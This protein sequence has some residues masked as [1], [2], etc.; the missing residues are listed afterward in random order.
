MMAR[1]MKRSLSLLLALVMCLSLVNIS[2]FATGYEDQVMDGYFVVGSDGVTETTE[3]ATNSDQGYTV[4]KTINQTGENAF[5]ITLK[6]ETQQT[7]QTNDAAVILVI[8]VS[9]SMKSCAE[10]GGY[11]D[12]WGYYYHGSN[13]PG[14]RYGETV[15]YKDS[16]MAATISAAKNF[17]KSLKDN[18][19]EGGNLY[20][21]VVKFSTNAYKVCDWIDISEGNNI[22]TVNRAIDRLEADGGTNLDA[23]LTLAYNRLGMQTVSSASSKYTVLLTDGEPTYYYTGNSDD[24]NQIGSTGWNSTVGGSG[25]S[26]ST[27]TVNQAISAAN[28][29]K[30]RS[31][32]YTI[33][34]GVEDD[35]CLEGQTIHVCAHCEESRDKHI[36]E[37]LCA[38]CGRPKSDHPRGEWGIRWCPTGGWS[39]WDRKTYYFC[40]E[41]KETQYE[42]KTVTNGDLTVGSFLS[43]SIATSPD[44]AYNAKDTAALNEAFK[45]IADS[46]SEGNTGAG[47]RVIDPM[48]Q[49]ITFGEVTSVKGGTANFANNTLTWTLDPEEAQ[50][51]S[52]DGTTTYTFTLTY[53]ITLDTAAEGFQETDADGNTKYYPTNGYTSLKVPGKN[54]VVFNVPGVCG[55]IPEV[56]Y[57]IEYYKWDK[58]TGEYPDEPTK[59]SSDTAKV[60][61][62]VNAPAGYEN[63]YDSDHYS[64]KEGDPATITVSV[65]P[66]NNV[67]RLYYKPD[68]ATVTV[69]HYYRE[70]VTDV[71]GVTTTGTYGTPTTD[72]F[73][74]Y[75]GDRYPAS[76]EVALK[77]QNDTYTLVTS[78]DEAGYVS[79]SRSIISVNENDENNVIN[80]YYVKHTDNRL[81]ASVTLQENYETWE[82][83]INESTGRYELVKIGET[84][85]TP[86]TVA[87]NIRIPASYTQNIAD[88]TDYT[89]ES[90]TA[91]GTAVSRDDDKNITFALNEG[92][93]P[94]VVTYK[95]VIDNRG[96]QV[97][98]TIEH[99]YTQHNYTSDGSGLKD[100]PN[101]DHALGDTVTVQRYVGETFDFVNDA[102]SEGFKT[103]YQGANYTVMTNALAAFEVTAEGAT[104]KIE[105]ERSVYPNRT[106]F[107]VYNHFRT[108]TSVVDPETGEVS[109]TLSTEDYT[110]TATYPLEG[111]GVTYYVGQTHTVPTNPQ[112]RT[113]YTQDLMADV[114]GDVSVE[115]ITL[116]EGTNEAHVYFDK[117]DGEEATSASITV[118]HQYYQEVETVKDG[119]VTTEKRF[120][121]ESTVKE[122][123]P[124]GASYTITPVPEYNGNTYTRTDNNSLTASYN[125]GT[126]TLTYVRDGGSDL[127]T[128]DLTV[129][130]NY[131]VKNMTVQNGVAGYYESPVSEGSSTD[132]VVKDKNGNVITDPSKLYVGMVVTVEQAPTYNGQTY[133]ARTDN[134]ATTL[135]LGESGTNSLELNYDRE[136]PLAKVEVTVDHTY[137]EHVYT[138]EGGVESTHT[139]TTSGTQTKVDKYVGES[140]TAVPVPDGYTLT[141]A[142]DGETDIEP[143]DDAY[144]VTVG[145]NGNSIYFV[146]EKD[147]G[148]RAPVTVTVY[149]YYTEIDWDG[150]VTGCGTIGY[151]AEVDAPVSS[152]AGLTYTATLK[153]K[154]DENGENG[155]TLV[156][157][158][159]TPAFDEG[160]TI[161]LQEGLNEIHLYYEK[162]IDSRDTTKVKVIHN[163]YARDNYTVDSTL[164][165]ADYIAQ[166]GVTPEYR[167][168]VVYDTVEDGVWVGNEYTATQ[169]NIVYF[170]DETGAATIERVYELV[171]VTPEGGKIASLA[172]MEGEEIPNVIVINMIRDYST[173]PG[174]V[175]YTVIHEYYT[176]GNRT[177]STTSQNTGKVG[178][179]VNAADIA[180]VTTYE[181]NTY[182]YTSADK[183]SMTLTAVAED[184]V[185]TLRYDRTTGG[186]YIP[187]TP[188]PDPDP[189]PTDPVDPP[190]DP[191]DPPTEIEDEDPPLSDL[192]EETIDDEDPPLSDLPE[193]TIDD[194]EPPMADA[195]ETGDNLWLWITTASLSGLGLIALGVNQIT[196]GRKKKD[197]ESK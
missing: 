88:K 141:S 168:E 67:I 74:A 41:T 143:T 183:E 156:D 26:A 174:D 193:E 111:S 107:T 51:S 25:S 82:W 28:N 1:R 124:V 56:S 87:E 173:D 69:N 170:K 157:Q 148:K 57:T 142:K 46:A 79:D 190:T 95:K 93:N 152:Y 140:Y 59:S 55:T 195:P 30:S 96:E 151:E 58:Q 81:E 20:V 121:D 166:E 23:G 159:A 15:A 53:S 175:S 146:Y 65:N 126:V 29:V 24:T 103:E 35:V 179:V 130:H 14:H 70:D 115:T 7:V 40:D 63:E 33:C 123:G 189:D 8:D 66:D 154:A 39:S 110:D 131:F 62:V 108:W 116:G 6:V 177:G 80:L 118:I 147:S 83:Q 160:L 134:P 164:S 171:N 98:V 109:W 60:G 5:D 181:G 94:I 97:T 77:T 49:Y 99:Y 90:I 191:T 194:E 145:E 165:D 89:V 32:L 119:V 34:Y 52:K 38:N 72:I 45:D 106:T 188:T 73:T 185:I 37:E 36:K 120:E 169:Y 100:N 167:T 197:A 149:H 10:C 31:T 47:T 13:C 75:V 196:T 43:G 3:N 153:L 54:D 42:D 18:N 11:S 139:N 27:E 162:Q 92:V 138:Y 114:S 50:T 112:N 117:K 178:G 176:D 71:N 105:Y 135:T 125:N 9:G 182:T 86:S 192:P 129:T 17:V 128:T 122:Y 158:N 48:G 101:P 113:G 44:H 186:G 84:P 163:Y 19:S 155:Y 22:S 76:G 137:L 64:Y 127:T 61:T 172:A 85:G 132:Y 16:R 184:N 2:A 161:T 180:K 133:T 21:S 104:V 136:N 187:P 91:N 4:S 78:M 144:V 68:T 150:T 102:D 12:N